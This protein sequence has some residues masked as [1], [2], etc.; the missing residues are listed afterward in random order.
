MV[1]CTFLLV[2]HIYSE[3]DTRPVPVCLYEI[4]DDFPGASIGDIL[5]R[6]GLAVSSKQ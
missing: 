3:S 4:G 1:Y 6:N 2:T 5:V